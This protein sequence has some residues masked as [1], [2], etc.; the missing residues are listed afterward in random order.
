MKQILLFHFWSHLSKQVEAISYVLTYF[1]I[2]T[3]CLLKKGVSLVFN[4]ELT[5]I[6]TILFFS[7]NII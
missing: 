1:H 7:E 4:I 2:F 5:I 6:A 3:L